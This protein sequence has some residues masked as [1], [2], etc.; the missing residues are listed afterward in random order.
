MYDPADY[1]DSGKRPVRSADGES[2]IFF[3][4]RGQMNE[5]RMT[6][7]LED[8]TS[9]PAADLDPDHRARVVEKAEREG[10]P[11]LAAKLRASGPLE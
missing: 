10:N 5:E 6:F 1:M 2:L 8:G 4:V 9:I 3:V 11:D 7:D